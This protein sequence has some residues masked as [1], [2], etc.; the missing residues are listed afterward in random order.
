MRK[1][2]TPADPAASIPDPER[3][4]DLPAEGATV[5]WGPYWAGLELRGD[6][7]VSADPLNPAP[8]TAPASE[9]KKK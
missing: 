8:K 7:V 2:V 9:P 6:V 1:H 5:V 3:G 4:R